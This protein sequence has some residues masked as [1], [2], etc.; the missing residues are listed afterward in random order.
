MQQCQGPYLLV[1]D[2]VTS[3]IFNS[4]VMSFQEVTNKRIHGCILRNRDNHPIESF[5]MPA[6][7]S[8]VGRRSERER[9]PRWRWFWFTSMST[10]WKAMVS[11]SFT[12]SICA[13]L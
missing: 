9:T 6:K 12:D 3:L 5:D 2:T 7:D 4:V 11:L 13:V 10:S 1:V 8:E